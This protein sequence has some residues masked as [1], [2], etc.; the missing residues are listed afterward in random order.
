MTAISN[1]GRAFE[2]SL[3]SRPTGADTKRGRRD[4]RRF[5]Y[6]RLM[7]VSILHNYYN[8]S[9]DKSRDFEIRPTT[10]TQVLMK[11]LGLIFR[12]Q[13]NGFSILYDKEREENLFRF[14][15]RQSEIEPRVSPPEWH[16]WT[17]LSF[18][19]SLRNPY[20][21]NFTRMP[22]DTNPVEVNLYFTN[23]EAIRD[24]VGRVLLDPRMRFAPDDF[25][26]EVPVTFQE[27]MP[28]EVDRLYVRDISGD[29]LICKERC[30][31]KGLAREMNPLAITCE[32]VCAYEKE[33][34]INCEGDESTE[35][36][37]C[38]DTVYL[39]FSLL[40]EDKYVI[41]KIR[42]DGSEYSRDDILYTVSYPTP[43]CFIDLLLTNPTGSEPG[44]YP[45][46]DIFPETRTR[47]EPVDYELRF[48]RRATYWVYYIVPWTQMTFED[49]RIESSGSPKPV[50]FDGPNE[51]RLPDGASAFC[52]VSQE[53]IP[54]EERSQFRFHLKGRQA[55]AL[56]EATIMER[57][58]SASIEQVI[59]KNEDE[60][61]NP[62]ALK[63]RTGGAFRHYSDIYV[64][65]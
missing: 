24:T 49:L 3:R 46:Q 54:L 12:P 29:V 37:L 30:V 6:E 36:C 53:R 10:A 33:H 1:V 65:I 56:Q 35:D 47:V 60:A 38:S 31:P 2:R 52:F 34:K 5:Y 16:I 63:N 8:T 18:V 23:Q 39:D 20:F 44:V 15:R 7:Q 32:D 40:P 61:C 42:H 4:G 59:P 14:L 26:P 57:L 58:P 11:G 62:Q 41:E 45:I 64:Y 25:L 48:E 19:L 22:L 21:V 43:L 28:K 50:I 27:S 55:Y 13:A 51:V 17:R 9:N